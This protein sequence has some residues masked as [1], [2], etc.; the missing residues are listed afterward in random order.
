[1]SKCPKCTKCENAVT[2]FA[3]SKS[4]HLHTPGQRTCILR[5]QQKQQN[6]SFEKNVEQ[7][8]FVLS[9]HFYNTFLFQIV[10]KGGFYDLKH[11]L[12]PLRK[13][14]LATYRGA[15]L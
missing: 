15:D 10:R 13:I 5:R 3:P 8:A 7:L 6:V 11:L 14:Y 9:A 1:M 2:T 12:F 4:L